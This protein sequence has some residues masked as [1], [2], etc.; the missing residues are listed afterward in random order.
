MGEGN[1]VLKKLKRTPVYPFYQRLGAKMTEFAGYELPLQFSGI[2]AEH[3]AVR[4]KAGLFDVSHM[5][6]IFIRG[7][8]AEAY[9]QG[10]LT[11]DV[12][13]LRPGR[14]QYTLLCN[15]D[16]GTIDD[17]LCYRLNGGAFLLVVNAANAEKVYNWLDER[18]SGD[19]EIENA[20]G[21]Y[22]QLALQGPI[23]ET[24]LTRVAGDGIREIPFYGFMEDAFIGGV[25]ALISRTG[26]TGEDGFEIYAPSEKIPDLW[27]LL[28]EAGKEDGLIPCGLG[29]RDTLRFEAGLPLYGNELTED[30]SPVEAGLGF[31]VKTEKEAEFPGK[32]VLEKQKQEGPPRKR[33]GLE[34]VDRGIPRH[35]YRVFRGEEEVGF[36]TSGTQSPTLKTNVGMALVRRDA[37][38]SGELTVEIRGRRLKAKIIP[39]PFYRR[40]KGD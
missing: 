3:E 39:L 26:Y 7:K 40:K 8:D 38:D 34:M 32:T 4:T 29:A 23:S 20:G 24:I 11:N 6:E 13:K 17:L 18:R 9:L 14:A 10:L 12:K 28:L 19:V 21:S 25:R 31:A 5:G 36:I 16:G 35:G 22:G 15:E 27:E 2:R 30:I 33:I 1:E 37:S